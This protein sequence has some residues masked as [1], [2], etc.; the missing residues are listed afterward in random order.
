MT[1]M[2]CYYESDKDDN[3]SFYYT[4]NF[5]ILLSLSLKIMTEIL[6]DFLRI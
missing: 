1:N 6:S 5:L 4:D 2:L 3:V